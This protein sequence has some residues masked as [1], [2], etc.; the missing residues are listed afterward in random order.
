MLCLKADVRMTVTLV[1]AVTAVLVVVIVVAGG[2]AEEED[3]EEE[4]RWRHLLCYEKILNPKVLLQARFPKKK[5]S[6]LK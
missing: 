5:T 6:T 2:R 3:R 1:L 4:G